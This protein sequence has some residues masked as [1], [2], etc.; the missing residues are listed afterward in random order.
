MQFPETRHMDQIVIPP[1]PPLPA[2]YCSRSPVKA[3]AK[4][5]AGTLASVSIQ[6]ILLG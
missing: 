3:L 1:P 4:L 2:Y 6:S 5:S